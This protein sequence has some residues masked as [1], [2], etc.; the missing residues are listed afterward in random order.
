MFTGRGDD[1]TTGTLGPDR[2]RKDDPQ[3]EAYGTVD[4]LSAA[5]GMARS[6][7]SDPSVNEVVIEIQRDLFNLMSELAASP[8]L[9]PK[10][11]RIDQDRVAWL[12]GV[13][14]RMEPVVSFPSDFIIA[15]D[16][17]QAAAFDMAR[18][19]ARRAERRVVSLY[20]ADL[21]SNPEL[22]RYLNRLSS[23]LFLYVLQESTRGGKPLTY[24]NRDKSS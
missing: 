22:L 18:S 17:V 10:F 24:A 23:L 7:C 11:R 9:Q 3:P 13:I 14:C 19:I 5:L 8:D 6:Q 15:G 21:I 16:S 20:Y 4:E 2:I 12:E 1:G